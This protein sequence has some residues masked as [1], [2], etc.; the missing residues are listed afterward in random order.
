MKLA[1]V[2]GKE[3][4][5]WHSK[6][7]TA[8]RGGRNEGRRVMEI[9][10]EWASKVPGVISDCQLLANSIWSTESTERKYMSTYNSNLM[11][12]HLGKVWTGQWRV[13][14]IGLPIKT[15]RSADSG[16]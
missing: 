9:G 4:K 12:I 3:E 2:Y 6:K 10:S 1:Q 14:L 5:T 7:L 8:E 15:F 13:M 11:E 16:G